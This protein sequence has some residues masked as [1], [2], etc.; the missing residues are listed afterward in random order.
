MIA[1]PTKTDKSV[2]AADKDVSNADKKTEIV[3]MAI[4]RDWGGWRETVWWFGWMCGWL[5]DRGG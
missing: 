5:E 3:S 2:G 4:V 1:V